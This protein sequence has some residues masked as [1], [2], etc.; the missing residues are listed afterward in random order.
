MA[1]GN[2]VIRAK[3]RVTGRKT[4]IYQLEETTVL[5]HP[6]HA[7]SEIPDALQFSKATPAGEITLTMKND[8]AKL[9]PDGAYFEVDFRQIATN[10]YGQKSE[11]KGEEV[12]G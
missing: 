3:V 8:V 6:I 1:T 10:E 12:A 2:A 5:M 9:F 11:E 4:V 7:G